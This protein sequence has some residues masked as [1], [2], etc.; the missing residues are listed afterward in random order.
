MGK[1]WWQ[2]TRQQGGRGS[3]CRGA[4]DRRRRPL[5]ARWHKKFVARLERGDPLTPSEVDDGFLCFDTKDFQIGYKAFLDKT[6]P[7]F[8]GR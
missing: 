7:K 3:L 5:V 8:E 1:G 6:K 4:P 2:A